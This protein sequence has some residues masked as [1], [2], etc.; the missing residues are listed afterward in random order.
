MSTPACRFCQIEHCPSLSVCMY[1]LSDFENMVE[2]QWMHSCVCACCAFTSGCAC[3]WIFLQCRAESGWA[4][5]EMM[6]KMETVWKKKMMKCSRG[7]GGKQGRKRGVGV[8]YT[9]GG[10]TQQRNQNLRHLLG[11]RWSQVGEETGSSSTFSVY[12]RRSQGMCP[13]AVILCTCTRHAFLNG[14]AWGDKN[15]LLRFIFDGA[16]FLILQYIHHH[17]V[18]CQTL[19]CLFLWP[20][21]LLSLVKSS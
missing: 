10:P 16:A 11:K 19:C 21:H 7:K 1:L 20:S 6:E 2:R 12:C 18:L 13:I 14:D 15:S 8:V 5:E 17:A 3:L 9:C 4:E